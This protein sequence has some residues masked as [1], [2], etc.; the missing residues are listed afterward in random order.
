MKGQSPRK[1]GAG[2]HLKTFD[3][4]KLF[5]R[6]VARTIIDRRSSQRHPSALPRLVHC[7]RSLGIAQDK[8]AVCSKSIWHSRQENQLD[9]RRTSLRILLLPAFERLRRIICSI[10]DYN[11]HKSR[12]FAAFSSQISPC[13]VKPM[14]VSTICHR[15]S[16]KS[17]CSIT[18][19]AQEI[20]SFFYSRRQIHLATHGGRPHHRRKG[21]YRPCGSGRFASKAWA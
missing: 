11:R 3:K 14:G 15:I 6:V 18:Q 21:L 16:R 7:V 1:R 12:S 2:S 4:R 10:P 13:L 17:I 19:M 9:T 5:T 20:W 8:A